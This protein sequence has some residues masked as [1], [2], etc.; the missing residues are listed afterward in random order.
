M[1]A[2]Q[3]VGGSMGGGEDRR[4]C[5]NE[6]SSRVSRA[7]GTAA[8]QDGWHLKWGRNIKDSG[9]SERKCTPQQMRDAGG[10]EKDATQ[11]TATK[12]HGSYHCHSE[13]EKHA[14]QTGG[15]EKARKQQS[16]TH[17]QRQEAQNMACTPTEYGVPEAHW[18]CQGNRRLGEEW[19]MRE[20]RVGSP[21]AT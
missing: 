2:A 5:G 21:Q 15:E 9:R 19:G 6:W 10:E 1:R 7:P 18:H 4:E 8:K 11:D 12:L 20:S 16:Q 17:K 14:K 13:R 3:T